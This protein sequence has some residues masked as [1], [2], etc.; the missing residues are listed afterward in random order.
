MHALFVARA[1]V[2]FAGRSS[3]CVDSADASKS[4]DR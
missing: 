1:V 2:N 4:C 3:I